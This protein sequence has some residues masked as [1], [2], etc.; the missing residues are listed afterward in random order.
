MQAEK[1]GGTAE[2]REEETF[3]CI[4]VCEHKRVA[5]YFWRAIFGTR[6]TLGVNWGEGG[7]R[8]A[9]Q[10]HFE[11]HSRKMKKKKCGHIGTNLQYLRQKLLGFANANI[12]LM[13]TLQ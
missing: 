8:D 10:I 3:E 6:V 11:H 7:T 1:D 5:R 13:V 9:N 12:F 2:Q 4:Q